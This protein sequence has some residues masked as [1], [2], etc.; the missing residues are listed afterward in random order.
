MADLDLGEMRVIDYRSTSGAPL[1]AVVLLPPSFEAGKR[2]PV[3]TWVY[4]GYNVRGV[5]DYFADPYMPG[6]YNL[7]L[8]AARGYAVLIPSIPLKRDGSENH[9]E[10]LEPAVAPAIDRLIELG[11]ADADRIGVM[12][13]SY[14]G[15]TT[16]G[17]IARSDR[18]RAA[19]AL[20][21]ISDL[22]ALV[23]QFDPTAAGYDGI[24]HE[25]SANMPIVEVGSAA[26]R[27]PFHAAPELYQAASPLN[28]VSR[29]TTPVLLIH[30]E[31]DVRGSSYQSEAFFSGLWRQGKTARI[32]RYPGENHGLGLSPATVRSVVQEIIRWFDIYLATTDTARTK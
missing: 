25:K 27:Q 9:L 5:D 15:Y 30:G 3:I 17:L 8:Y 19:V 2:F 11:I 18:F 23:G 21:S 24:E 1:K 26:M 32:V 31:D 6:L 12:G 10:R 20:A 16:L 7:R 4:G 29:V 28:Y 14:G 13:Q 22:T